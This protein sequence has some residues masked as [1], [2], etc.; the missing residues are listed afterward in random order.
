MPALRGVL[1]TALYADDLERAARFYEDVLSLKTS[2]S[3]STP[4]ISRPGRS[5]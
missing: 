1:E 2:P 4:P 5:A 3:R